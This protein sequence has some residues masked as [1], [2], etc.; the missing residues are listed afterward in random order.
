MKTHRASLSEL[1]VNSKP[2]PKW[3]L[4]TVFFFDHQP[5]PFWSCWDQKEDSVSIEFKTSKLKIRSSKERTSLYFKPRFLD[6]C[7]GSCW[8]ATQRRC[9]QDW[10]DEIAEQEESQGYFLWQL[11]TQNWH[12]RGCQKIHEQG[13][14]AW[15]VLTH[16]VPFSEINKA[17]AYML[18]RES[19]HCIITMGAWNQHSPTN[20]IYFVWVFSTHLSLLL[21]F[22]VSNILPYRCNSFHSNKKKLHFPLSVCVFNI[23]NANELT[24]VTQKVCLYLSSHGLP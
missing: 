23:Q 18:K 16:T 15:E 10:S 1:Q 14:G 3:W 9:L 6:W 7:C 13:V 20:N 19:I 4:W 5:E 8:C 24:V 12:S 21:V 17:F 2:Q 11:Q 22:K